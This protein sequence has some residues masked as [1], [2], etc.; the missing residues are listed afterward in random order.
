MNS[1]KNDEKYILTMQDGRIQLN[2]QI[3]LAAKKANSQSPC[4]TNLLG[5]TIM[6]NS[7]MKTIRLTQNQVVLVD[8]E[9]FEVLSQWKW[10]ADKGRHTFYALRKY[11][12]P[13]DGKQHTIRMHR[14]ILSTPVGMQT[15][16][17]DGNGLNNQRRNLRVCTCTENC[18]NRINL[19]TG[20]S[21]SFKG[22][23]WNKRDKKWVSQIKLNGKT[24]S[25]GYFDVE[26]E[27]AEAY[28]A[29]AVELFGKFANSKQRASE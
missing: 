9:D 17:K 22:V 19:R 20:I 10:C 23:H 12:C 28:I 16:H 11:R 3:G 27:A 14:Q 1:Q 7:M 26:V 2:V 25:L 8:D 13:V 4:C 15:D 5:I 21:S 6:G 29:K 18:Q 24:I